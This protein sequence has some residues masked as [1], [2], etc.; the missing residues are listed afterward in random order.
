MAIN[1]GKLKKDVSTAAN[2]FVKS[3]QKNL[4]DSMKDID[5]KA[6]LQEMA[7]KGT[8][9]VVKF[10]KQSMATDKEVEKQ[11]EERKKE[12]LISFENA[13][14]IIYCLMAVDHTIS[15]KEIV[16]FNEIGKQIDPLFGNYKDRLVAECQAEF[17][18][19]TDDE[20]YYDVVHDYA[21]NVLRDSEHAS[22]KVINGK[23]L[24]WN[25]LAA[26]YVDEGYSEN[27]KRLI[28]YIARILEI[29]KTITVEMEGALKTLLAIED[30]KYFLQESGRTYKEVQVHMEDLEERRTAILQGIFALVSD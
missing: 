19:A 17:D 14:R 5:V 8:Q 3:A 18:K 23:T 15:E 1:F 7:V 26:A 29:D 20:D 28:K 30:D 27:E 25:L 24:Y 12:R 10:T 4:P 11:L 21:G 16:K 2:S 6:S 22:E 13:M 9:A